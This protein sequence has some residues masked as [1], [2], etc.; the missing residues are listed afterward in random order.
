[1]FDLDLSLNDP[2][3]SPVKNEGYLE[4]GHLVIGMGTTGD[5]DPTHNAHDDAQQ[6]AHM[7]NNQKFPWAWA[8]ALFGL[9]DVSR[10]IIFRRRKA[11]GFNGAVSSWLVSLEKGAV[12]GKHH[13]HEHNQHDQHHD[14]HHRPTAQHHHPQLI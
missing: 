7:D 12:N 13:H 6:F 8:W 9:M 14:Y 2:V 1:M 4:T 3:I 10:Y 5:I 11:L